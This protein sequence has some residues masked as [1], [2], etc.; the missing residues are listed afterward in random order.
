MLKKILGIC[1]AVALTGLV[2]GCG[3]DSAEASDKK[4]AELESSI[5]DLDKEIKS[6]EGELTGAAE[7]KKEELQK[8]LDDSKGE[9]KKLQADLDE[10]L[11]ELKKAAGDAVE[12]GKEAVEGL[13][14][15]K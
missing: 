5:S 2:T 8:K 13:L 7:D 12:E 11:A 14:G 3:G 4:K 10:V 9:R 6:L 1:A 15:D